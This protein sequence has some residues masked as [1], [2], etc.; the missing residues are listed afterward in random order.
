MVNHRESLQLSLRP[1]D[2]LFFRD[3]RPFGP[4][5]QARS[6]LPS[7]QTLTGA[8]RTLLLKAH[9]I[10]LDRFSERVRSTGSF[11]QALHDFGGSIAI[12]GQVEIAGPW[13]CR[14]GQVLMPVPANLK[15]IKPFSSSLK[16]EDLVRL[17]PLRTP[18]HGWQPIESG[19]LPLWYHGRKG[20][21]S[22]SG[23]YLT[24]LGMQ[25]YLEGGLPEISEIVMSDKLYLID[26]RAG[27][28]VDG[29]SNTASESLIYSA[30]MLSLKENVTFYAEVRGDSEIISPLKQSGL[31]MKFGGE[32]RHVEISSHSGMEFPYDPSSDGDRQLMVLTTAAWFDGWKPSQLPCIAAAVPGYDGISGWD[33]ALGGPKPNRFLVRAG[34][35]YFFSENESPPEQLVAHDDAI[36]GWGQYLKGKWNYV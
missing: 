1:V 27:I 33:L 21:K 17:D 30:G 32:G 29:R 10:N 31:L 19:L 20:L 11:D 12:L 3:A 22:L 8:L 13:L 16:K 28:G 26:H 6:G 4:A 15:S 25:A 18:P 2:T 36:V 14:D 5:G 23:H 9:G 24:S 34:S 7:P 35:V